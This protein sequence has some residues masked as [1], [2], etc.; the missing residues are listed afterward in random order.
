MI[1]IKILLIQILV[2]GISVAKDRIYD[3]VQNN[4]DQ[5]SFPQHSS[6]PGPKSSNQNSQIF[7][8]LNQKPANKI[9]KS[10]KCTKDIQN[11]LK[12]IFYNAMSK[13][14]DSFCKF[15][16]G[17]KNI[18]KQF[19]KNQI[20]NS[21]KLGNEIN[22]NFV[23]ASSKGFG[24]P[25]IKL[26]FRSK[27]S[28][29][30]R[31]ISYTSNVI[32]NDPKIYDYMEFLM[33]IE[34]Y[35]NELDKYDYNDFCVDYNRDDP[36]NIFNRIKYEQLTPETINQIFYETVNEI[37]EPLN[38]SSFRH[39]VQEISKN[40][41]QKRSENGF[42]NYRPNRY[43]NQPITQNVGSQNIFRI[44]QKAAEV[45]NN[46]MKKDC[47]SIS[48]SLKKYNQQSQKKSKRSL[49][50]KVVKRLR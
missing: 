16:Y 46:A 27:F 21:S 26:T 47:M 34:S 4:V 45:A 12:V 50:T 33:N 14:S 31:I 5:L 23:P 44:H 38:E 42:A 48:S 6:K 29:A 40:R 2:L 49:G 35:V 20:F 13:D 11:E 1:I 8:N 18:N 17:C 19:L 25:S 43:N 37:N 3:T 15:H 30:N 10:S 41:V 36:D 22:E 28:L 24:V 7:N 9:K 39:E 32:C